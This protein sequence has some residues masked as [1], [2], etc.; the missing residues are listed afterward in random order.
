[1]MSEN[2]LND[3]VTALIEWFQSQEVSAT[4]S[5]PVCSKVIC[6]AILSLNPPDLAAAETGARVAGD[7]ILGGVRTAWKNKDKAN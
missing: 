7:M 3:A 5:V 2:E 6:V 4:D 1:M